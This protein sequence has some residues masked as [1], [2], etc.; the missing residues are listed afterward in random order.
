MCGRA[1]VTCPVEEIAE[2]LGVAP[3]PIGPPR[4][5]VAPTQP[6]VVVRPG[7]TG[8][9]LGMLTWGLVPARGLGSRP[10]RINARIETLSRAPD[11][12]D[13]FRDRRCLIVVDG[14]YEW[15]TA[16]GARRPHHIR[17][18][19]GG[20]FTFAGIWEPGDGGMDTCTIVTTRAHGAIC[21]LHDRMPFI[22]DADDR[23]RWLSASVSDAHGV[24]VDADASQERRAR[25]LVIVP[26]STWV[27]DVRHDDPSCLAAERPAEPDTSQLAFKL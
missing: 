11:Y 13:G 9:E 7:R 20:P 6:I 8:R 17:R 16:G 3:I 12:R 4:Y 14:F 23:D 10:P 21:E 27:N 15:K 19:R 22:L 5:N 2:E 26:V 25:E 18:E 1:T 24:V